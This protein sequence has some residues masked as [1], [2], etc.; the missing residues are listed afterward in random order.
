MSV[1][2]FQ[3]IGKLGGALGT[4]EEVVVLQAPR[5]RLPGNNN[6]LSSQAYSDNDSMPSSADNNA[7]SAAHDDSLS[8]NNSIPSHNDLTL[9]LLERLFEVA[10]FMVG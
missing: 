6:S 9:R 10:D 4:R 1:R 3:R 5:H 8:D 7:L 2:L